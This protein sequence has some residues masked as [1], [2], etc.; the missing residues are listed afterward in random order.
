[1]TISCAG[2]G[3]AT[4]MHSP[5]SI[6]ATPN[7]PGGRAAVAPGAKSRSAATA[8][9]AEGFARAVR[10]GKPGAVG[11]AGFRC[12][13]LGST[14]QAA[15]DAMGGAGAPPAPNTELHLGSAFWGLPERWRSILW[16]TK[17]EHLSIAHGATVLGVSVQ[18][19]SGLV[20]RAEAALS[21]RL[22][23]N[24]GDGE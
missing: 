6:G 8:A 11:P 3:G 24:F 7:R 21:K 17:A 22:D 2:L 14:R 16:V 10:S 13:L 1:M 4:G 23:G 9:V 19:A 20:E 12:L 5:S 15:M 18:G